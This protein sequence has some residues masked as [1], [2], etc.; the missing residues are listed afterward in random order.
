MEKETGQ[1]P[2]GPLGPGAAKGPDPGAFGGQTSGVRNEMKSR[3]LWPEGRPEDLILWKVKKAVS[4]KRPEDLS[5]FGS[6]R[7]AAF[8]AGQRSFYRCPAVIFAFGK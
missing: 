8:V 6:L 3:S 1:V 7:E 2:D 4:R 5:D